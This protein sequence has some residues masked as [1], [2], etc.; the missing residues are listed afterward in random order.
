MKC[1]VINGTEQKGCTYHLKEMF[2]DE[3]KPS[4]LKEF[5]FPKDAPNFC[6]G[7]KV[8]FMKDE[9]FCPHYDKVEPIWQA[10]LDADLIVFAYPVYVLR[11]PGQ[12]KTFL[13]HLGVHWLVHRPNPKMFTKTAAI[14]TQSIGAPNEGA[15][16]DVG[17][18]L[19]W[20]GVPKV[21]S[22]GFGMMEGVIWSEISEKRRESF[23]EDIRAFAKRFRNVKPI[24]MGLRTKV[25]FSI[26]K[27][28]QKHILKKLPEGEVPS[29]D[30]QY[31]L[32][33]GWIKR[34]RT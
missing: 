11:A 24:K 28:L 29:A 15:Q 20:L 30:S 9:K 22:K 10:M 6:I 23:E 8:C 1:V 13:D 5:Y 7:C 21:K 26:S 18:S 33:Q 25:G 27:M 3:L 31:W 17:A 2:L 14:I 16:K 19:N 32:N 4:E 12:I 34:K